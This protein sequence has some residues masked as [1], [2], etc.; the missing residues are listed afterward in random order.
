LRSLGLLCVIRALD[1]MGPAILARISF[2]LYLFARSA[3]DPSKIAPF[4]FGSSRM[5]EHGAV[6][7]D[8]G[9]SYSVPPPP[10]GP[11]YPQLEVRL[12]SAVSRGIKTSLGTER[13]RF[14]VAVARRHRIWRGKVPGELFRTSEDNR[15][16][17][18][19][20]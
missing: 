19:I 10:Q 11:P 18:S 6:S 15:L 20:G 2:A 7:W 16:A 4:S 8:S 9:P 14:V 3:P 12:K 17:E 1:I 5:R 13:R